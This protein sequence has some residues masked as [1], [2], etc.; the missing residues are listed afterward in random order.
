MDSDPVVPR[1][2]A[3]APRGYKTDSP[4]CN[5][6]AGSGIVYQRS[7]KNRTTAARRHGAFSLQIPVFTSIRSCQ[8]RFP[9][10]K[11]EHLERVGGSS[12]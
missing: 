10:R 11:W 1:C 5:I 7:G 9:L 8:E 4:L 6:R 12:L 2:V 3:T